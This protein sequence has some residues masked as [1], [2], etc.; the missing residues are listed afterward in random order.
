MKVGNL[1]ILIGSD[2]ELFVSDGREFISA[3]GMV[4][5]TK[6][7][8]FSVENGAVQVDG[9]ALEFNINPADNPEEFLAN[10]KSVMGQLEDMVPDFMLHAVPVADF[11]G[12]VINSSPKEAL[13]LGCDPDFNA[14][15]EGRANPSPNGDVS[16]RTGAGHIH[17]GWTEGADMSDQSHVEACIQVAKQLDMYLGV[18]SVLYDNDD[19]RRELY[20]KAGAFRIKPYGVEY[21]VLSN[22]WLKSDTLVKWVYDNTIKAIS[23]LMGG[24]EAKSDVVDIINNSNVNKAREFC[25]IH[26]IPL[27]EGVK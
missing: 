5:G 9:M 8:P 16:F 20:G 13:E 11:S 25:N 17:I 6:D 2:P 27:P 24:E 3:H 21:R 10:M 19:R 7:K 26:S 22:A 1:N 4:E 18:P 15:E 23:K 14:W 12:E